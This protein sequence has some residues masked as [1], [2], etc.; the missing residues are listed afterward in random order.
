MFVISNSYRY[1]VVDDN[2][3]SRARCMYDINIFILKYCIEIV[4]YKSSILHNYP[5]AVRLRINEKISFRR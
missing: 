1:D 4:N 3:Y 5:V 2:L